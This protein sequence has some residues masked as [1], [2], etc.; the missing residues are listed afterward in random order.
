MKTVGDVLEEIK[1]VEEIT[2]AIDREL[3]PRMDKRT[4]EFLCDAAE[5]LDS[6]EMLLKRMKLER[7]F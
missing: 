5:K 4:A 1:R 2:Q 3:I 6:Y 7:E